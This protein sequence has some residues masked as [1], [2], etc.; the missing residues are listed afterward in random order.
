VKEEEENVSVSMCG[1]V[2]YAD[3]CNHIRWGPDDRPPGRRLP[4]LNLPVLPGRPT[5]GYDG[6]PAILNMA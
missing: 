3:I 5:A 1:K 4:C 2:R 6:V